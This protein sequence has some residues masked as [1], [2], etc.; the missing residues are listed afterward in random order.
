MRMHEKSKKWKIYIKNKRFQ[1]Q[2][3]FLQHNCRKLN[4]ALPQTKRFQEQTYFLQHNC[5][6]GCGCTTK[7]K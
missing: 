5:R 2:T 3:Y 7:E 4:A 6:C 1:E